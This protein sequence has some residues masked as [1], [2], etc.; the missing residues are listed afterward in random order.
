MKNHCLL[1]Y[2]LLSMFWISA[3]SAQHDAD[4]VNLDSLV[5]K[6]LANNPAIK[7]AESHWQAVSER[8]K[9]VR[10]LPDPQFSYSRFVE[11]VETRVGPQKHVFTLSQSIPFPGKLGLKGKIA[12]ED[13]SA[14]RQNYEA[15]IR[16]VVFRV[17][18]AYYDL[19]WVD[20][21]LDILNRYLRLLTDFTKVAGQKYATGQGIQANVL[22]SQVE[23]S[24]VLEKKLTFQK[25][26]ESIT[27]RLSRLL[28]RARTAVGTVV[29]IDTSRLQLQEDVLV[30]TALAN[31]EELIGLKA[32][33]RKSE[34]KRSLARKDF[35]P[36]FSLKA[37][38]IDVR[39]GLST[40]PDAGKDAWSLTFGVNLPI[41]LGKRNAAVREAE[42]E[43]SANQQAF[44]DLANQVKAE[45]WDLHAQI[46]LTSRTLD[47]Y[48]EGLLTQAESS[49]ES[50]LSS[51]R[52]GKLD[53]L[54]LLDA[55]RM[56][57]NLNLGYVK[58]QAGYQKYVAALEKA[59]GGEFQ[60]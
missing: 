38:Y 22:K 35:L 11:S 26:R 34:Y 7:A 31:R 48:E 10:S 55:E 9:Q 32:M 43:I 42:K 37:N 25:M 45:V 3:T 59:V 8:P 5:Q 54:D 40:A 15:V 57:L 46:E 41:W 23:V 51:Y 16:D 47:L 39:E 2:V 19:Y 36:D 21:S 50:A 20:R 24:S 13:A 52:T 14:A 27:A 49:L 56:L 33:V 28:N 44:E 12:K 60:Q 6:A 1:F 4:R 29:E 17:K 53:F 18:S 58:E 30:A